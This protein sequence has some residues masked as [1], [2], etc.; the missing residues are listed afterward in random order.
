QVGD[1]LPSCPQAVPYLRLQAVVTHANLV[2][3][4]SLPVCPHLKGSPRA[5]SALPRS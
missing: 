5:P 2:S 1:P 3:S 4:F